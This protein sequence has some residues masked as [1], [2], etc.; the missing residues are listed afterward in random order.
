MS[1]QLL[2]CAILAV[3]IWILVGDNFNKYVDGAEEF[4]FL[5]TGAYIL[6][7]IGVVI[8]VIGFLGCCGAIRESQVMLGLVRMALPR[9]VFCTIGKLLGPL[10]H[11]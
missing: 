10:R 5:Q 8:M 11:H 3:G 6:I 2:G 9:D 7:V 1:L 4:A